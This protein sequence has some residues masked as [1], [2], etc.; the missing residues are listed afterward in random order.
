MEKA[1]SSMTSASETTTNVLRYLCP[2]LRLAYE[3]RDYDIH[4]WCHAEMMGSREITSK[5]GHSFLC[6]SDGSIT[7]AR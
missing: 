7:Q 3:V 1:A 6:T 5:A 4:H 2:P